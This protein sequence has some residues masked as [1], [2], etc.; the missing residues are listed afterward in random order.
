VLPAAFSLTSSALAS[1]GCSWYD[2]LCL[3]K[4]QLTRL[5]L[6]VLG[7]ICIIGAIYLYK[8]ANKTFIAPVVKGAKHAAKVAA[9]AA[10]AAA[11]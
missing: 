4:S 3:G 9:E 1:E 11:E 10:A 2:V 6:L 7:I 5:L 8:P